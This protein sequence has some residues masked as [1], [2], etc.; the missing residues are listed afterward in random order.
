MML[1]AALVVFVSAGCAGERPSREPGPVGSAAE[2][3][4]EGEPRDSISLIDAALKAGA[5][6]YSTGLLYKVYAVFEP[7]SLPSEFRSSV[8]AKCGTALIL[9]VQRSWDRLDPDDRAEISQHVEPPVPEEGVREPGE[10]P[11]DRPH[12]VP[13]PEW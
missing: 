4:S 12:Y 2:S 7:M 11:S 5:I 1:L 8:P 10:I 3:A 9:E 13:N 6:D